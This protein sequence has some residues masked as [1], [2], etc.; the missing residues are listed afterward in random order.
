MPSY[1]E[2]YSHLER[3]VDAL[4]TDKT[5]DERVTAAEVFDRQ[6]LMTIYRFMTS[7]HIDTVGYPVSTGKEGN[8][9]QAHDPD[10][11]LVALKIFRTSTSTFKRISSYIEGDPRFKGVSGNR[12]K[13][14]QVWAKKEFSNLRLYA[15]AG[16]RVPAPI[17]FHGNCI[18]MEF[19][20]DEEGPAPLLKDVAMEDPDAVYE[21][22]VSWIVDGAR[23]AG[24]VH[25]DLSEFNILM[26]GDEPVLIDCGQSMLTK[27]FNA[28]DLLARDVANVN[29]FFKSRGVAVTDDAIIINEALGEK[30]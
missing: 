3:R 8:V 14:V 10:G 2:I 17:T 13:M 5:G 22:V 29:R 28:R 18:V 25:G 4:K 1:D 7:G 15:E 12:R 23:D 20:G 24:L 16:I 19:I 27:H 6:T 26:D 30:A 9:F 21:E 11:G